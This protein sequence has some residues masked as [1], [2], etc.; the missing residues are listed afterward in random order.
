VILRPQAVR[1]EL[2][3]ELLVAAYRYRNWPLRD[4]F[5]PILSRGLSSLV[6][7]DLV[8]LLKPQWPT[9]TVTMPWHLLRAYRG[10]RKATLTLPEFEQHLA[11]TVLHR[12]YL[13]DSKPFVIALTSQAAFARDIDTRAELAEL[14]RS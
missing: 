4:R 2:I 11:H 1:F 3:N 10:V 9:L 6:R 5:L 7:Q 14:Q 12:E 13:S 8:N